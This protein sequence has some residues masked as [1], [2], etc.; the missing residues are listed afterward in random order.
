MDNLEELDKF[1]EK[2]NL[3]K[4][5]QEERVNLNR[6]IKSTEIKTVSRSLPANKKPRTRWLHS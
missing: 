5:N 3:T 6:P 2:Y 4:V 1:I